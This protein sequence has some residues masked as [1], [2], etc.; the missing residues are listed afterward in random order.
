MRITHN[1]F[2]LEGFLPDPAPDTLQSGAIT[3]GKNLRQTLRGWSKTEG[4]RYTDLQPTNEKAHLFYFSPQQ[5]DNRWYVMGATT[6][7]G[8]SGATEL[9]LSRVGGYSAA[10]ENFWNAFDFNGVPVANNTVDAPQYV[11]AGG[12]F[13]DLTGIDSSYRFRFM[14]KFGPYMLGIAP[15]LGSGFQDDFLLW[16]HPADPGT[17]PAN[18]DYADPASDAGLTPLPSAGYMLACLEL[19]S[20]CIIYK[21]DS[22]WTMLLIGGVNIFR[23]ENKFPGQGLL[24]NRCVVDFENKHFVVTQNDIMV[25]DSLQINSIAHNRVKEFFFANL[26]REHYEKAF[27]IKNSE[28]N[29]VFLYY[30]DLDSEDGYCN[31]CL[32]WDWRENNWHFRTMPRVRHAAFGYQISGIDITWETYSTAWERRGSWQSAEDLQE[33]APIIHTSS[34]DY[35][36]LLAPSISGLIVNDLMESIW[37]R[38]DIVLGTLSRDGVP[39]QDYKNMKTVYMIDFDVSTK[40]TFKVYLGYKNSLD[41]DVVWLDMGTVDPKQDKRIHCC[42]T[43]AFFSLRLVTTDAFFELRNVAFEFEM[44]GEIWT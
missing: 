36:Y 40:D 43:A 16:S 27:V 33:Y 12:S 15:D 2:S 9:D 1:Q 13:Q 7:K 6:I 44:A 23:F 38:Q 18:W 19:G 17:I 20:K 22:I 39:R 21:S 11:G 37:E 4:L 14:G 3:G 32:V 42:E 8:F 28:S 30:P 24:N 29:E 41:E 34:E 26:N 10:G 35:A 25:H 31:S 5:G